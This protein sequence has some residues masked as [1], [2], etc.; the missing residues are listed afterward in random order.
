MQTIGGEDKERLKNALLD[1]QKE[2]NA[3]GTLDSTR[4]EVTQVLDDSIAELD[5]PKPNGL[6]LTSLLTTVGNAVQTLAAAPQA[7]HV[8]K[9][10]L[11]PFG[12]MLP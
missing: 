3:S 2:I 8:L 4:E 5:K 12:I 7:Y 9:T 10:A 11:V 1:V 6:K